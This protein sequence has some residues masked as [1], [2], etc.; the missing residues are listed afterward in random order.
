MYSW[1]NSPVSDESKPLPIRVPLSQCPGLEC[2]KGH[3]RCVATSM[4]CDKTVDCMDA[5]DEIN[6]PAIKHLAQTRAAENKAL[7]LAL[8]PI[9]AVEEATRLKSRAEQDPRYLNNP[10]VNEGFR[11]LQEAGLLKND[12]VRMRQLLPRMLGDS[13]FNETIKL[14]NE[15]GLLNETRA[16][17]VSMFLQ[18]RPVTS[19]PPIPLS[20]LEKEGPKPEAEIVPE[21]GK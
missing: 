12:T 17:N 18:P 10:K 14:F 7:A 21:Q 11:L 16:L 5:Q 4:L 6:C 3:G 9:R 20:I 8:E 13:R 2:T 1:I 15:T 19:T